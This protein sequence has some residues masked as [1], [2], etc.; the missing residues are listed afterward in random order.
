MKAALAVTALSVSIEADKMV[1]QTYTSGVLDS[2][3]CGTS[4]DHAVTCTGWGIDETTGQQYW[5]IK[6]SWATTWGDEGYI[7]LAIVDGAGICGVQM[8]PLYPVTNN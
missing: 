5:M 2:T 8:D 7:R 4:L 3:E 1:F 6:N